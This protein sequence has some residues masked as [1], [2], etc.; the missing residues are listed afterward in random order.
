M[1]AW[2][3][4]HRENK[5]IQADHSDNSCYRYLF[6]VLFL[7][8]TALSGRKYKRNLG[9]VFQPLREA[10]IQ[11]EAQLKV[12]CLLDFVQLIEFVHVSVDRYIAMIT[13][14]KAFNKSLVDQRT[15][16]LF[17]VVAHVNLLDPDDWKV[18]TQGALVAHDRKYRSS[19]QQE[20]RC[21]LFITC[22][23]EMDFG[24]EHKAA[25]DARLRKFFFKSL[26]SR[27]VP[28]VQ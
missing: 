21:P 27:P 13:E 12:E 5:P 20:I 15:Q 9:S 24:E 1:L 3:A 16:I 18:L 25:M 11:S 6:A 2:G 26:N 23:T 22:Q 10:L 8:L 28:G 14:Q 19:N 4:K 17:M 7:F